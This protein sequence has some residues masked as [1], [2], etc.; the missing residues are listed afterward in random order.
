MKFENF[1]EYILKTNESNKAAR[2]DEEQSKYTEFFKKKLEK[3]KVKSPAELSEEDKKKFFN[4]I[5]KEWK[6][7]KK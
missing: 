2:L 3:Y 5:E 4:E 7:D 1:S 6:G